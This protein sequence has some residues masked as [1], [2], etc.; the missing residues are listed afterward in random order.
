MQDLDTWLSGSGHWDSFWSK[1]VR[2]LD[3]S[4]SFKKYHFA[5]L[6]EYF[7]ASNARKT[8]LDALFAQFNVERVGTSQSLKWVNIDSNHKAKLKIKD[9]GKKLKFK[10]P[11]I[12]QKNAPFSEDWRLPLTLKFFTSLSEPHK[13]YFLTS[14]LYSPQQNLIAPTFETTAQSAAKNGPFVKN[15]DIGDIVAAAENNE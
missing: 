4:L 11:S 6:R 9:G 3:G 8:S 1:T 7:D 14:A 5:S 15:D 12:P 10:W 13:S 2:L